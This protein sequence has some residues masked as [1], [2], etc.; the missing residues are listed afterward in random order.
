MEARSSRAVMIWKRSSAPRGSRLAT[1][2][3]S[4]GYNHQANLDRLWDHLHDAPVGTRGTEATAPAPITHALIAGL[5]SLRAQIKALDEQIAEHLA[6][7]PDAAIFTS[8]PRSG[9]VRAAR[10]LAEIGD[11]RGK[12]PTPQSLVC[13]FADVEPDVFPFDAR[14]FAARHTVGASGAAP[15]RSP[16]PANSGTGW[17]GSRVRL[18]GQNAANPPA[19]GMIR[20]EP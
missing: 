2:L 14:L 5:T 6:R 18:Q 20:R 15:T 7:H 13:L 1:W 16:P 12:Y 9:T 3:R 10:L 4:T 11:A 19:M 17:P 8:L